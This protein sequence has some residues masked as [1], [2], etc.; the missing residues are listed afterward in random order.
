VIAWL[1]GICVLILAASVGG[2]WLLNH[3]SEL[4]SERASPEIVQVQPD[5]SH[6][7]QVPPVEPKRSDVIPSEASPA[8][9][10]KSDLKPPPEKPP[11]EKRPPVKE[12]PAPP[13][14]VEREV[15]L[16][17]DP[18]PEREFRLVDAVNAQRAQA[19]CEPIFLD[20]ELSRGCQAHARYLAHN[21]PRLAKKEA[22]FDEE[23]PSLP[24]FR[25]EGRKT[26]PRAIIVESEPLAALQ[27]WQEDP[28]RR[29]LILQPR[30]AAFGAGFA[31]NVEGQ[32]FSVFDLSS[33][34]G[35][36]EPAG[37]APASHGAV[38]YPVHNQKRV[39]LWFPGNET[40][41]PL[42]DLINK[43]AGYPITITFPPGQ[44]V[45]D[46]QA[47]LE[48]PEDRDVAIWLST[49]EKPA[50]PQQ[51]QGQQNTICLLARQPLR[52]RMRY[53]VRVSARVAS[54]PWNLTW[55]FTTVSSEEIH[56]ERAGGVLRTLNAFRRRAGLKPVR[57]EVEQSRACLA[58]AQY[59]A[60]NVPAHPDLNWTEEKP[61]LP[62]FTSSGNAIARS[63]SIQGGGG[64]AEVVSGLIDSLVTR[65]QVLDPNLHAL[66]LGY[67]PFTRGSLIWVMALFRNHDRT[68]AR[69]ELLYPAPDQVEVPLGYPVGEVPSPIPPNEKEAGYAVTAWWPGG[70]PVRDATAE[71]SDGAGQKVPGWLSS[72]EK[73][74][75][76]DYPQLSI[77]C[78]PQAPLKP[79][80]R[81]T[82]TMRAQV[83]E[84]PWERSWSFTT[85]QAPDSYSAK[86]AQI[87]LQRLN[88][89]RQT[90]GLAPV[91]LDDDLSKGCQAHAR[92]LARN[93]RSPV[94]RGMGI[95]KED[96]SLPGATAEG[97]RAGHAAV[98][99]ILLD[100]PSV[101]EGW[102]ATLYHRI[103][104]LTPDLQRVGFGHARMDGP[105]WAC[106]L[107]T[108]NG[109]AGK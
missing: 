105:K 106:V 59:L 33:G 46:V 104:L 72:P 48:C 87:I 56:H 37:P 71:V 77:C 51:A 16:S 26:A 28:A 86:L 107:D 74:A 39:P 6:P 44:P 10:K 36:E 98:I 89:V 27:E 21:A 97:A 25:D 58:H 94:I 91:E 67:A 79:G 90:A 45:E 55:S 83:E 76:P 8:P 49:P 99:A 88:A 84:K 43:V 100:P 65:H 9:E 81:Y 64:P 41:D 22:K 40:P 11:E 42:P 12:Q 7:E 4:P 24:G 54:R 95:H 3:R 52:P 50:N 34:I 102:M 85:V 35:P 15:A 101:V 109:K 47:H 38:F 30:L 61:D 2:F 14:E 69:T 5:L 1:A 60:A 75:I 23:D 31:R 19:G 53:T 78:I 29:S 80:T 68:S 82:V 32:W 17:E 66:G 92:Y 18:D 108:R 70:V 62:G 73:P 20:A 57:L 93:A 63:A 96:P 103:P 13:I